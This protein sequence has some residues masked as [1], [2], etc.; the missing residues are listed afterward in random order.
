MPDI[1]VSDA[2]DNNK[3][4]LGNS[5]LTITLTDENSPDSKG[6]PLLIHIRLIK[7]IQHSIQ[8]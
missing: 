8:L 4:N 7:L 3:S 5:A 1:F 6:Q 2:A